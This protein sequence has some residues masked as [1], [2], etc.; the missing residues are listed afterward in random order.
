VKIACR[1]PSKMP[2]ER[3]FELER[4][5]YLVDIKVE[6][7]EQ[8][9]DEDQDDLDDDDDDHQTDDKDNEEKF[10]ELDDLNDNMETDRNSGGR[11]GSATPEPKQSSN[12]G[13]KTVSNG[14]VGVSEVMVDCQ[15]AK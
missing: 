14:Q 7:Y 2:K 5:L 8:P 4:K 6:G 10:D 13:A 3:L 11:K 9:E 15:S 1:Q 12:L